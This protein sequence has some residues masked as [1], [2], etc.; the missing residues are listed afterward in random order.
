MR[1][2]CFSLLAL[3]I[4]TPACGKN[5]YVRTVGYQ[6]PVNQAPGYFPPGN[7]GGF[8]PQLPPGYPP[9]YTP[10]LPIDHY[11]RMNPHRQQYWVQIWQQWQ[12]YAVVHHY[13]VYDFTPFWFD[14]CQNE[15]GQGPLYP[16]YDYF[17]QNYYSWASPNTQVGSHLDPSYFWEGYQGGG[18]DLNWDGCNEFCY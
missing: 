10:F 7:S 15:W 11:M 16:M 13:P 4:L 5:D 18:Y 14:F 3:L 1:K 17:N 8:Q 2:G 6:P 9:Q 12:V